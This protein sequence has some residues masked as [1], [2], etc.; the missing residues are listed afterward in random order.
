MPSNPQPS[1]RRAGYLSA[2]TPTK[3]ESNAATNAIAA[4]GNCSRLIGACSSADQSRRNNEYV[5]YVRPLAAICDRMQ[6][7]VTIERRYQPRCRTALSVWVIVFQEH[8][9]DHAWGDDRSLP[10]DRS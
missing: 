6:T 5:L 8:R 10:E 1:S 3:G 9:G 2:N 7:A 4:T